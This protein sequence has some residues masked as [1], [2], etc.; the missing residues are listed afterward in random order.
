[1][2]DNDFLI[3]PVPITRDFLTFAGAV[4]PVRVPEPVVR[5]AISEAIVRTVPE[6]AQ[7][8]VI[9][10]IQFFKRLQCLRGQGESPLH[11]PREK[12]QSQEPKPQL[13]AESPEYELQN[14]RP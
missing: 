6:V 13:K 11:P 9:P 7:M 12:C 10:M 8:P 1:M 3:L 2:A 4:V 5:V 14:A